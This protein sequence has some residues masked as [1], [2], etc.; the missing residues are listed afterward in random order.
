MRFAMKTL[1]T[2]KQA[3]MRTR[4]ATT[5]ALVAGLSP[6][7][8]A[9]PAGAAQTVGADF[10][11]HALCGGGPTASTHYSSSIAPPDPYATPAPGVITSWSYTTGPNV[12]SVFASKSGS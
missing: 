3:S 12:S 4:F 8:T 7:A 5:L 11:P 2:K 6:L 10:V 9:A 1:A